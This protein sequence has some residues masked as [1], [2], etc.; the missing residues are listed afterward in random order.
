MKIK[1]CVLA[2]MAIIASAAPLFGQPS[3]SFPQ[4]GSRQ[5][6]DNEKSILS[7]QTERELDQ[8]LALPP[9]ETETQAIFDFVRVRDA[10]KLKVV[11]PSGVSFVSSGDESVGFKHSS[12]VYRYQPHE[13]PDSFSGLMIHAFILP[14]RRVFE[15]RSRY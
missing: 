11:G 9:P 10:L 4:Y 8:R 12:L 15:G 5:I 13:F 2:A 7:P 1:T 6:A 3:K 14:L